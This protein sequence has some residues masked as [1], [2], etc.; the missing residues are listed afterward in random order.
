MGLFL[1]T[2]IIPDC[3]LQEAQ[4]AVKNAEEWLDT[5]DPAQCCYR[6]TE[7][8]TIVL[9][10]E[11]CCGYEELA[12]QLT[13]NLPSPV[14]LLYIY[15]EDFWGYYFYEKGAE[16][17]QFSPMPDYFED[18]SPQERQRCAGNSALLARYFSVEQES[19]ERYL[20]QWT[21]EMVIQYEEDEEK[22]YPDDEFGQC[23]CWQMADFMRKLGF[24]YSFGDEERETGQTVTV[25]PSLDEILAK[26]PTDFSLE[27]GGWTLANLP[28]VLDEAYIRSIITEET[29]ETLRLLGSGDPFRARKELLKRKYLSPSKSD[30]V[31]CILLAY[32]CWWEGFRR[33]A[34]YE[35]YEAM[36][37]A[38][39]FM[40][41]STNGLSDPDVILLLRARS[42]MVPVGI[43]RHISC[44]DLERLR[45]LDPE[46]E[47]IYLLALAFMH[48]QDIRYNSTPEK[49]YA[50]LDQLRRI[51]FPGKDDERIRWDGFP[52][53]FLEFVT[54]SMG[55]QL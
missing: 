20:R 43:K 28:S 7:Q 46:N 13:T 33:G 5:L 8:G 55:R 53:D 22:A 47:D 30:P 41:Q 51:G 27:E 24:P 37:P 3:G 25:L 35:L 31:I 15:D 48:F 19:I 42:L 49:A 29:G 23:D 52:K 34:Y 14:L 40:R 4:E 12:I 11:D 50:D 16:L 10:N 17:D 38:L 21:P 45:E 18:C 6:E 1:Q 9:F 36:P 32:C 2:A 39:P 44:R 26:C 54:A